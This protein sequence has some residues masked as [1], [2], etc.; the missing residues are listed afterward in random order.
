MV[1][2][3]TWSATTLATHLALVPIATMNKPPAESVVATFVPEVWP[4]SRQRL[5][6]QTCSREADKKTKK[7]E[8]ARRGE[9]ARWC[10]FVIH[11]KKTEHVAFST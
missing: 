7:I 5:H 3:Q 1:Q 8:M 6:S 9:K 10:V 11:S 2:L 4:G